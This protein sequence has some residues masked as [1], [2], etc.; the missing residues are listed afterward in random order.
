M[1]GPIMLQQTFQNGCAADFDRQ[2][3]WD[4]APLVTFSVIAA[5][6]Q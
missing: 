1:E 4:D 5:A 3:R 6:G 2:E